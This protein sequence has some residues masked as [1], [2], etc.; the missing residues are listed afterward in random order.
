MEP[1]TTTNVIVS[2]PT[3]TNTMVEVASDDDEHDNGLLVFTASKFSAKR[4]PTALNQLQPSRQKAPAA[5]AC[6]TAPRLDHASFPSY[7]WPGC[8]RPMKRT[9]TRTKEKPR[10]L[11]TPR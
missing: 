2:T 1:I 5:P 7:S 10:H 8:T 6:L 11:A 4:T 9:T 3:S